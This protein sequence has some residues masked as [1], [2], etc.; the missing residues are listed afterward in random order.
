MNSKF[1]KGRLSD[2]S[3]VHN[4]KRFKELNEMRASKEE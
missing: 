4:L 1:F 3:I 2:T